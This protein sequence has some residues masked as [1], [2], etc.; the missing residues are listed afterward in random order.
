MEE[1]RGFVERGTAAAVFFVFSSL[2]FSIP[3]FPPTCGGMRPFLLCF[4]HFFVLHSWASS[5]FRPPF[6]RSRPSV[7][8]TQSL[9]HPYVLHRALVSG[10]RL[11]RARAKQVNGIFKFEAG[12]S[13]GA[14]SWSEPLEAVVQFLTLAKLPQLRTPVLGL[15]FRV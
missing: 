11:G 10:I 12:P 7:H 6:F 1:V 3:S 14:R 5:F 9:Q 13:T 15:G 4:V 2:R 8:E